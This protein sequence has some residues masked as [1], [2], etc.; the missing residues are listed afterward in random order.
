MADAP[1]RPPAMVSVLFDADPP[2]EEAM[3]VRLRAAG[4]RAESARP[5]PLDD[6]ALMA[7]HDRWGVARL[8]GPRPR[9]QTEF[10]PASEFLRLLPELSAD[11][12]ASIGAARSM[13]AVMLADESTG[14]LA[15]LRDRKRLLRFASAA[16][17]GDGLGAVDV[18]A[19][20]VWS[21][22]ELEDELSHD[23]DLD[24]HGLFGLHAV[25]DD[26]RTT[27]LHS[28]G[29]AALGAFDFDILNPSPSLFRPGMQA[30]PS[31]AFAI[32]EGAVTRDTA[33]HPLAW[34]RG[35]VRFVPAQTFDAKA[36]DEDRGGRTLDAV[37]GHVE[38]RAVLCE[39]VGF[40][41][42][43]FGLHEPSAF[44]SREIPDGT[45]WLLSSAATGLMADRARR[46][47]TVLR[48]LHEELAPVVSPPLVKLRYEAVDGGSEH[49][50]FE[51]HRMFEDRLEATLT[52]EP[53]AVP[54]LKLGDR[55]EHALERLGDWLL[56][57]PL[58][59]ITP[60]TQAL[61]RRVRAELPR[62]RSSHGSA[63]GA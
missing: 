22:A 61:A 23:A 30:I 35:E 31:I 36:L 43:L 39:P 8:V 24:I 60:R 15:A 51:V 25:R 49:L 12:V 37:E 11:E 3:A 34:P 55:G 58:G 9:T 40:L 38:D 16:M 46:T 54:H 7:T 17:A 52:N 2:G 59:V 26:G 6:W 47:Y 20:R 28:H 14:G 57:S 62:G 21:P 50:W 27:W 18:D 42:R 10:L 53:H 32:L 5:S 48:H 33:R 63:A 4:V 13:V 44:L 29:L 19:E 45:V 41:A 56:G 1:Q